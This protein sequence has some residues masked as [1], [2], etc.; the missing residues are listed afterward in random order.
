MNFKKL[1]K[2]PKTWTVLA[3]IITAYILPNIPKEYHH[4]VV[5]ALGALGYLVHNLTTPDPSITSDVAT[6]A[7]TT[8]TK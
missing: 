3:A 4:Q 1:L 7:Q 2:D 6:P 8:T 5:V